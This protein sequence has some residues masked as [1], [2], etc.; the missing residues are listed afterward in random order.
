MKD[1]I[2]IKGA[3]T[4]NLKNINVSIPRNKLCVITGMS[5]SGKSSLA[6]DTIYAEGQRRYVESLSAYARQF[7]D[8][9]EKPDVDVIEGLSPAVSVEQKNT[10][11]NPRSTVGTVTEIYDY[12]RLLFARVGKPHCYQCGKAIERQTVTQVVETLLSNK[13]GARVYILAPVI[14]ERKGEHKK[15]LDRLL[16]MGFVRVKVDDQILDLTPDLDLDKKKKHSVE[17]VVDRM[18]VEEGSRQRLSESIETA[19]S[20]AEGLAKIDFLDKDRRVIHTE[21]VSANNACHKCGISYPNIEPQMFSFNSPQG[22]CSQCDGLGELMYV[23]ENLVV[24]NDSLSIN[25]GAIVPWFGKKTNYY[26]SMLEAV[27]AKFK[28]SLDVPFKSLSKGAKEILFDGVSDFIKMRTGRTTYEG[29]FEG[30]RNNLMRRY[31]ETDSDW[32]RGEIAKFMSYQPCP[33]CT[34]RR[35]RRESLAIRLSGKNIGEVCEMSVAKQLDFFKSLQLLKMESK[36]AAPILKEVKERLGFLVNVGLNY[37]TLDRK[38]HTLSGGE[39]QRIRLASQIGSALVGVT[40][41]LDEPSIGL[42]QRDNDRLI[43]TL[44][45]LRDIG[46]TVIVVEHDED[47]ILRADHVIDLGPKAGVH[48]GEV[49]FSGTVDELKCT[50]KS[51]TAAYLTHKKQIPLPQQRR[52]GTGQSLIIKGAAAN[53]LK[54]IDVRFPLGQLICVTGVSGSGKSSLVNDT[55]FPALMNRLHQSKL[56]VGTHKII[57]G[58]ENIDKVINIDQTP[59]G[60]TPRSNP[61]T[62]TGLFTHIRDLFSETAEAKARGYK[63]GRFSFNV[64]G[65]RCEACSGDGVLRIEMHFLP[66]VYVTCETCRG[67]RFNPDTLSVFFK[68]KNIADVLHMTIEEGHDFFKNQPP[69]QRKLETLLRVGLGYIQLGQAATTLSGGEA[70][71]VKLSRELAKRSTGKTLYILDEP[72]TGL[73]FEDIAQLLKVLHELADAGNTIVIVEHNMHIIKTADTIIDLGPE[74]GDGGGKIVA[75][76]S[77][78]DIVGCKESHTGAHLKLYANKKS[79]QNLQGKITK[80][81]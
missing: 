49:V 51:S 77:V 65:G 9:M 37:L 12:L 44:I 71:R 46:N 11:H 81:A 59:I 75:T 43:E 72:T 41:V 53:N 16:A 76:G 10:S 20:L 27:A 78:D 33:Q 67:K 39:A 74:G 29:F 13:Q 14:S 69:I 58:Y 56:P 15:E 28:F 57:S 1:H 8:R 36:I 45:G 3:R 23:D 30:I 22:A 47:T 62:Y 61:A 38:S 66:D 18:V 60:R 40:Y 25:A 48:G 6:F 63:P 64:E 34:G 50:E 79:V 2:V 73:H 54:Q 24:P 55:L 21:V 52:Q 17:V 7:L 19:F 32:M 42:H 80:S 70:Q 68:G 5:G 31:K 4:H 35:L 26:Q